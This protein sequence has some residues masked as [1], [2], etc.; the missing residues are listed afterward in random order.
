MIYK[1]ERI[2][3]INEMTTTIKVQQ[4]AYTTT[5]YLNNSFRNQGTKLWHQLS[6]DTKEATNVNRLRKIF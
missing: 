6:F 3:N 1:A 4:L 5:P 2:L